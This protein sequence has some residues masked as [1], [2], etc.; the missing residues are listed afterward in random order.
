VLTTIV[1]KDSVLFCDNGS[2]ESEIV[3]FDVTQ[4]TVDGTPSD[5][6]ERRDAKIALQEAEEE[7]EI[8]RCKSEPHTYPPLSDTQPPFEYYFE[9]KR[10]DEIAYWEIRNILGI[11]A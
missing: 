7:E 10:R 4:T 8:I 6:R 1:S 11:H 5:W 9:K 2:G 3:L